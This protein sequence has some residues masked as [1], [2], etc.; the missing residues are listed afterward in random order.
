MFAGAVAFAGAIGFAPQAHAQPEPTNA[1][2]DEVGPASSEGLNR[3]VE[4]LQTGGSFR[5]RA[6]A[7]VALGRMG[8]ARALPVLADAL[9]GDESYA[10]RAAAAA[11]LGRLG[12]VAGLQPLFGALHD[13]DAY[14]RT[15]ATEA[16]SRFRS[17]E[18]LFAFRDA[19]TADDPLQR[20]AAVNA[21]GDVMREPG[22]SPGLAARVVDALGD[23]DETVTAAAA[24]AISTLPHDRA[25]PLLVSGLE[26][27]GSGVRTGC[28]RLLEKRTDARAVPPLMAIVVDTDQP[29][30][31]R[32]AA[33]A[34]LRKH[35]E[36]VDVQRI[37]ADATG[38][39]ADRLKSLRLLAVLGDARAIALIEKGLTDS[40]P[41]VRTA[42]AR[43][44][45][46][47]GDARAKTAL[48]SA[49]AREAEP[50]QKKQLELLLKSMR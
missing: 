40:D 3:L 27:G 20:L 34:A 43:A 48:T 46:D 42:A 24:Q 25:M 21:Y 23:D 6:T 7:A 35:G 1:G 28:A 30:D 8:D 22:A 26:H 36:Y 5:V 29:E 9:R 45:V 37:A 33:G 4:A 41:S 14:V 17:P 44:A 47:S 10:V 49:A 12:D 50:R 38:S 2:A 13:R 18:H 11:A 39:G 15:E 16:L 19:L 32:R 31:V